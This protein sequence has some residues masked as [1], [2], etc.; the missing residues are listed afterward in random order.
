MVPHIAGFPETDR[1]EQA[2]IQANSIFTHNRILSL[3]NM[4]K[5]AL[6]IVIGIPEGE[7]F[8]ISESE[9]ESFY[10]NIDA[11]E[12]IGKE[13]DGTNKTDRVMAY[14]HGLPKDT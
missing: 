12:T 13:G 1:G 4:I 6:D 10:H 8:E 2:S 14:L 11:V 5:S 3:W 9:V 7:V